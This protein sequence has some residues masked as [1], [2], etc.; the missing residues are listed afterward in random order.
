[1]D[2]ESGS[3]NSR[4]KELQEKRKIRIKEILSKL[5]LFKIDITFEEVMQYA[6]GN[7]IGRPHVAQAIVHKGY[8]RDFRE[9]FDN[10]LRIGSPAYVPRYKLTPTEAIRLIRDAKGIPVLAHPGAQRI[11]K[12]INL[13]IEDGLQ[14]IEVYH[15]EHSCEDSL[16][17][18]AMAEK[19]GLIATGGSDFHGKSIKTGIDI[20]DKGVNLEVVDQLERLKQKYIYNY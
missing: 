3:F 17:Y 7:S 10:Y 6:K 2:E 1:L 4:I 18:N 19:L 9:A 16:R 13:W 20:G 5:K 14:G 11:D 12:E 15:P 8:A